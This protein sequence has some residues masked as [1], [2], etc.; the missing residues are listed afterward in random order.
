MKF[1]D[2][3]QKLD[4]LLNLI[5]NENTGNA[6]ELSKHK[7]VSLPALNRYV[8]DLRELGQEIE[9]SR[10]RQTYFLIKK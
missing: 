3:K 9:Y 7:C 2:K 5:I 6:D 4:F 10:C 1:I 8:A